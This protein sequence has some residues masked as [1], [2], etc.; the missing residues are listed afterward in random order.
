MKSDSF[1]GQVC[2]NTALVKL[3]AVFR[4][5]KSN[6]LL[7]VAQH[8]S[9]I[10]LIILKIFCH[11]TVILS[12]HIMTVLCLCGIN[13]VRFFY[14]G[15]TV[16]CTFL[17]NTSEKKITVF[18]HFHWS[19]NKLS[20]WKLPV[21]LSELFI[22]FSPFSEIKNEMILFHYRLLN[23]ARRKFASCLSLQRCEKFC[24]SVA[25]EQGWGEGQLFFFG[26]HWC[27]VYILP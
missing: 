8:V 19:P 22:L 16:K 10:L 12:W 24:V 7:F 21:C 17:Y 26:V 9:S 25:Q 1:S 3:C 18:V 6:F 23:F 4:K 14:N 27:R 11:L 2:I 15:H 5:C 20:L 13:D